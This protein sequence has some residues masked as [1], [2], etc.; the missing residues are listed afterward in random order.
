MRRADVRDKA[1]MELMLFNARNGNQIGVAFDESTSRANRSMM[2]ITVTV[3]N[4][5]FKRETRL[6]HALTVGL[7][8]VN[9][10]FFLMMDSCGLV[11][12]LR[13]RLENLVKSTTQMLRESCA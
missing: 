8:L 4:K 5:D 9:L 6:A 3:L 11:S 12:S 13:Q 10:I 2:L 1:L 7:G